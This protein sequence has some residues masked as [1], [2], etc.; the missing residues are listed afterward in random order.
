MTWS[1][2]ALVALSLP[3]VGLLLG[4]VFMLAALPF[5]RLLPGGMARRYAINLFIAGDQMANAILG[6]NPDMTISGRLG[7]RLLK[8]RDG[9]PW[10]YLLSKWICRLLDEV[11]PRHCVKAYRV[12]QDERT[13]LFGQN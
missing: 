5:M 6:G 11:D 1:L 8:G 4:V 9:C 2:W 12:D 13:G 10:C 3:L 7:K